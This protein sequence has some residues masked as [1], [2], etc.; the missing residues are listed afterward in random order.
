MC[1]AGHIFP[2]LLCVREQ[3]GSDGPAAFIGIMRTL[4][5]AE[6]HMVITDDF[7]VTAGSQAS[8]VLLDVEPSEL[9][10]GGA[11]MLDW[12]E[13]WHVRTYIHIR[14]HMYTYVCCYDGMG[15]NWC[16]SMCRLWS[17]K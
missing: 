9:L 13:E 6:N 12:V 11:N 2:M 7:V 3:G 8:L 5:T 1:R 4:A 14:T 10:S 16:A 17:R 15:V